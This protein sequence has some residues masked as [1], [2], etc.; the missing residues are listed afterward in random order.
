MH[1]VHSFP[2]VA[3]RFQRYFKYQS[4][5]HSHRMICRFAKSN[6]CQLSHLSASW[7]HTKSHLK[8]R[9][10]LRN[11]SNVISCNLINSEEKPQHWVIKIT[12]HDRAAAKAPQCLWSQQAALSWRH[13]DHTRHLP[14][15]SNFAPGMVMI[16]NQKLTWLTT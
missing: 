14:R 16:R 13:S 1:G 5:N 3:I 11:I 6:L 2:F 4:I 15:N 7:L 8:Q 12:S 10:K 9:N